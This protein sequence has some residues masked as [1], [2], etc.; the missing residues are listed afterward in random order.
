MTTDTHALATTEL[1]REQERF[2]AGEAFNVVPGA[3]ELVCDVRA[4]SDDA[5]PSVLA[6]VPDEVV[7]DLVVHGSA[8]ACRARI[9][10]Y[11]DNGVTTSSLA[12]MPLDPDLSFWEAT[13]ALAPSAS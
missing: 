12:V 8:E 9:R 13:R 10:Q 4:D 3:G 7:D 1:A 2:A 11:F 5:F 6:A